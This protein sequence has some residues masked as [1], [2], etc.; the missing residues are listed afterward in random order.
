YAQPPATLTLDRKLWEDKVRKYTAPFA[1]FGNVYSARA[2]LS[3]EIQTRW[4]VNSEGTLLQTSR[5]G[6]R[7]SISAATKADDGMDL[8]RSETFFASRPEEL[9]TDDAVLAL[10]AKMSADLQ[11]LRTAPV[12]DPYAGPA[13]LSGRA[14]GVFFHEIFGHRIEGHRQK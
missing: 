10:V 8:P 4:Y 5:P 14:G 11:A 6:Y 2:V 9:P 3:A 12:V 7:L 1:R 13:I